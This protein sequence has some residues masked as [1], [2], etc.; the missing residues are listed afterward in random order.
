[1]SHLA[2]ALAPHLEVDPRPEPAP[3]DRLAAVLAVVI[4]DADPAVLLTERAANMSR[5][6][7]EMSFPGGLQDPADADLRATALRETHEEIGVDPGQ[8]S[9]IGALP[10]IHTFVSAILVTPFVATVPRMPD[11]AISGGEIARVLTAP[12]RRLSAAE[13]QRVLRDDRE[14]VWRGWWYELPDATVWGATGSMVH[15]LLALIR[16]E[17]P[18]VLQ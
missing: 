16:R 3:G 8:L 1:M 18:W 17:A 4:D 13:E 12:I 7:G 5:H 15:A 2:A 6:A 9:V 14:G 11:L 10:P